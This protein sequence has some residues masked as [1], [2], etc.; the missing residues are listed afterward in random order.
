M[1]S[2]ASTPE[3]ANRPK[4]I[5]KRVTIFLGFKGIVTIIIVIVV[6]IFCLQ[7]IESTSVQFLFWKILEVP[8]LYLVVTSII[9][10][11]IIG[12]ILGCNYKKS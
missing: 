6:A 8:K 7:N 11:L 10:G 5:I 2:P 9:I 4:G 12:F 1:S 3:S